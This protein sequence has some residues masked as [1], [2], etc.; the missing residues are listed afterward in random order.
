[1]KLLDDNDEY[2]KFGANGARPPFSHLIAA[3]ARWRVSC[4]IENRRGWVALGL[5][6]ALHP[7]YKRHLSPHTVM[8]GALLQP[9]AELLENELSLR[10]QEARDIF[11]G[12]FPEWADKEIEAAGRM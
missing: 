6:L 2:G 7:R 3:R 10:P 1:M 4:M 9:S 11:S 8:P 12:N 5:L